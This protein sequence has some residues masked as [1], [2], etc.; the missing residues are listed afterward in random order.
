[1]E[2]Y[3]N[4]FSCEKFEIVVNLS[5]WSDKALRS[6]KLYFANIVLQRENRITQRQTSNIKS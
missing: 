2:I 1:M 3:L 5:Q 4:T 6:Q